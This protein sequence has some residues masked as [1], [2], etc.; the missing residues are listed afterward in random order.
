[1]T[2]FRV[3]QYIL[4]SFLVSS[5]TGTRKLP[6]GE[7][8]YTGAE[9]KLIP[10]KIKKKKYIINEAE[11][12]LRP[13]PNKKFLWMRPKL[14]MYYV[15]GTPKK[16][17]FRKWLKEKAG[18]PPVL[19][20][21][22]RPGETS[23]FIDAKLF[24]IGIFRAATESKVVEKKKTAKVEYI[25]YVH[26][27]YEIKRLKLPDNDDL[28]SELIASD[29]KR[30]LIKEGDDYNLEVLRSERQRIDS[31]LKDNGYFYFNPDYLYFKADT[32]VTEK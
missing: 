29:Q 24:N 1:M 10:E 27:P 16:K 20:S 11:E 23:G 31:I 3:L 12:A 6:E 22:V 13:E 8:L 32:S 9:I 4:I 26:E 15:A 7:K 2:A 14:W 25:C 30:T 21:D 28:L 18:E 19:L 17:G 5:C